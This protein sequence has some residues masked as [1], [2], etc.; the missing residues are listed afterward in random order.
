MLLFTSTFIWS[1]QLTWR[2]IQ[3][4]IQGQVL[5]WNTFAFNVVV[6][7]ASLA[8]LVSFARRSSTAR[9]LVMVYLCIQAFP[10]STRLIT[11]LPGAL[12]ARSLEF[13]T[14]TAILII[15]GRSALR[16]LAPEDRPRQSLIDHS[17]E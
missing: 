3:T 17:I 10:P 2:G 5:D 11:A 16:L 4:A 6:L 9:T 7:S 14:I 8:A 15:I 1:V 12:L 13:V